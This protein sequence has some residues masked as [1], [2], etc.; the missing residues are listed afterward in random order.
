MII[1]YKPGLDMATEEYFD[2]PIL[3]LGEALQNPGVAGQ[4]VVGALESVGFLGIVNI[5]DFDVEKLRQCCQ[6]FFSQPWAVK[7][8]LMKKE[9]NSNNQNVYRGYF[10]VLENSASRKEG[11]EIAADVQSDDP[12]VIRGNWFYEKS[13]WPPENG[14]FKFKETMIDSYSRLHQIAMDI[15]K[16]AS[17]G[18][19][20]KYNAFED[21][22]KN[23][24][25]STFRLLHYP[26]W[27][28]NPPA[29]A[30]IEDNKV[31]TTPVH[32]DSCFLTLLATFQYHGLEVLTPEGKWLP[33]RPNTN[34][35]V[36]N[37]GD[38]FSKMVGGRFVATQ[39]RV[40]D[41]G[42]DR[43]SVPFFLEPRFDADIGVNILKGP[44]HEL[45]RDVVQYGPWVL[46]RMEDKGFFEFKNLPK[47]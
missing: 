18:L 8:S 23:K 30:L 46:K 11:F 22:F 7:S 40:L 29:N 13:I 35:L 5:P 33:V 2:I 26:P 14:D 3:D 6:W 37:V 17:I 21:L 28:G 38:L 12:E 4:K 25:C 1:R 20:F 15:L 19:G 27:D 24:P 16:L 44:S 43:F 47:F 34:G 45:S 31:V 32:T 10:P 36:M 41:I 9:F 39:H 42:I